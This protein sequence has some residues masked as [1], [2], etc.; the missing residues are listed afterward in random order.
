MANLWASSS[1]YL[2]RLY[3]SCGRFFSGMIFGL[4][5]RSNFFVKFERGSSAFLGEAAVNNSCLPFAIDMILMFLIFLVFFTIVNFARNS[6]F[7]FMSSEEHT[8]EL[9]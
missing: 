3:T 1:K 9:Y 5:S 8:S 6:F 7:A 2:I 4:L